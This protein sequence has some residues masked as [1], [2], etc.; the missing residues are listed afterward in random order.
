[1]NRATFYPLVVLS[2]IIAQPIASISSAAGGRIDGLHTIVAASGDATPAGGRYLPLFFNARLNTRH[3]VAFDAF[4][5]GPPITTGVFVGNGRTASTI[6][7]GTNPDPAAPSFGFVGDRSSQ[8]PATSY[9]RPTQP[10]YS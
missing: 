3:E 5:N 2:A 9:S 10:I 8:R 7:L 4:V 6:V 1:M